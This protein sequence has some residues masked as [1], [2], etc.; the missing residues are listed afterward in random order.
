M[1]K[2]NQGG[3]M[4]MGQEGDGDRAEGVNEARRDTRPGADQ[5]SS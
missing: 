4:P 2:L 5:T 3:G 1:V